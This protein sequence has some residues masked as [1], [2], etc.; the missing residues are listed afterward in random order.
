MMRKTSECILFF[1]DICAFIGNRQFRYSTDELDAFEAIMKLERGFREVVDACASDTDAFLAL[2]KEVCP[3]MRLIYRY[4][5]TFRFLLPL[6]VR[7]RMIPT[8]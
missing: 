8:H 1:N 5:F 3:C 2:I 7:D 4:Y 6:V